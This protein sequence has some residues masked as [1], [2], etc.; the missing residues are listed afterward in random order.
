M[1]DEKKLAAAKS[2][3]ATF[4]QAL[5]SNDWK[6]KKNEEK[7]RIDCGARGDDLPMDLVIDVDDER[8]FVMVISNLPFRIQEDKRVEC[9]AAVCA[10]NN[11]LVHGCFDFNVADGNMFFRMTNSFIDSILSEDLCAY[12]LYCACQT[13]DEYNDKFLMLSKGM[14]SLEKFIETI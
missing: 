1:A 10:V 14:L 6:Y 5:D 2:M 4:C 11:V 13:I 3:F 12:M 7:L 8:G 9:A